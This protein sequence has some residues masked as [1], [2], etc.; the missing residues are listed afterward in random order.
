[1]SIRLH[2]I[3]YT[4]CEREPIAGPGLIQGYGMLL[5]IDKNEH[6]VQACSKNIEI[7]LGKTYRQILGKQI[8]TFADII[9]FT[10]LL[11]KIEKENI[12]YTERVEAPRTPFLSFEVRAHQS[13]GRI[14]IE[15]LPEVAYNYELMELPDSDSSETFKMKNVFSEGKIF[16][17]AR[18]IVDHIADITGC[19]R[20]LVFK[21]YD[22]WTG[23]VIAESK[24]EFVEP[25]LGLRYPATDIPAQVRS[26]YL[27]IPVREIVNN[28]APQSSIMCIPSLSPEEIDMTHITLRGVSSYHL[29]YLENMGVVSSIS[30][31]VLVGGKLW[32]LINIHAES[33]S[34]MGSKMRKHLIEIAESFG[35]Y[36]EK[37]K[38][39]ESVQEQTVV[40][41]RISRLVHSY[42]QSH[43]LVESLLFSPYRLGSLVSADGVMVISGEHFCATGLHPSL[44]CIKSLTDIIRRGGNK[45]FYTEHLGA[46][47]E[48]ELR[49]CC[50][51]LIRVITFEPLVAIAKF[52]SEI[53]RHVK[54][55]GNPNEA[56]TF[57][58]KKGRLEP[59]GSFE[60]WKT[61]IEGRSLPWGSLIRSSSK[62][63]CEWLLSSFSED[64]QVLATELQEGVSKQADRLENLVDLRHGLSQFLFPDIAFIVWEGELSVSKRVFPSPLFYHLF[65]LEED[66]IGGKD[67][68]EVLSII[69][70]TVDPKSLFEKSY[71]VEIWSPTHGGCSIHISAHQ[72]LSLDK[73]NGPRSFSVLYFE[74]KTQETR[75]FNSL[76]AL[77][78]RKGVAAEKLGFDL[79]GGMSHELRTP[80]NVMTG[81]AQLLLMQK[82]GALTDNQR[83][84]T[85]EI[86]RAGK[87]LSTIVNDSL[88]FS[89]LRSG[90]FSLREESFDLREPLQEAF[91]WVQEEDRQ[92]KVEFK[93]SLP[94]S[95]FLFVG[96]RKAIQQIVL[97]LLSNAKKFTPEGG[98]ITLSLSEDKFKGARISA[99]DS[100]IGIPR[101]LRAR[102]FEPFFQIDDP[103]A[104]ERRGTGLGLILV[105]ALTELHGGYI[106]VDSAEVELEE[107]KG[108]LFTIVFPGWRT[109]RREA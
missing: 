66:E 95:E 69:G 84:Y 20:V 47:V 59:R 49:G 18:S 81:F 44:E 56:A 4:E 99:T 71:Q 88:D 91:D 19:S 92:K 65:G 33:P 102:I 68:L 14:L 60:Q 41:T 6:T 79:I 37:T 78:H 96:D 34:R 53:T 104:G 74:D 30:L 39:Q 15:L 43:D 55:G 98:I 87:H 93:I 36:I 1:M 2:D 94:E 82:E 73:G 48:D 35:K 77:S 50:G 105:R 17:T 24:H 40:A 10:T 86:I 89:K 13:K 103:T 58:T 67:V 31:S 70:I 75:R 25:F 42:S 109:S 90:K 27:T 108:S 76:V 3:D 32:G 62:A 7:Y 51:A 63:I 46:V 11:K 9:S 23:E 16:R 38:V 26:L 54:W 64:T 21:F 100:G 83:R 8:S 72:I 52:R 80:L 29:E 101:H 57:S 97:N 5:V 106:S 22:D 28:R 61:E 107:D 12:I 45:E 85:Q